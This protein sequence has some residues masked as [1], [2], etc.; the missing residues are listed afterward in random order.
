MAPRASVD[1]V[2][3]GSPPEPIW[4]QWRL[5]GPQSLC[6]HGGAWVTPRVCVETVEKTRISVLNR[7]SN[8]CVGKSTKVE[9]AKRAENQTRNLCSIKL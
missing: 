5:G 1:T 8:A 6:G 3:A 9:A 2:E 4:T 7:N